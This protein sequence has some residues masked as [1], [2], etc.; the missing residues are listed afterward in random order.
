M[1]RQ[2][3][4]RFWIWVSFGL[5][6][7]M[8][9]VNA[10]ANIIPING[11]TTGALSDSYFNLFAP[12]GL[13]FTVWGVIYL[14]LGVYVLR[15]IQ[16]LRIKEGERPSPIWIRV[17]G[18]LALSSLFNALWIL[19]WHYRAILVSVLLML[20]ILGCL[21]LLSFGLAKTDPLTKVTFGIYFGWITVAT[22]ANI[23]TYLVSLGVPDNTVGATIQ[24][25]I[26]LLVGIAIGVATLLIQKNLGYGVVFVW[27]YLGIYLKHVDPLQFDRGYPAV[28]N[29]ALFGMILLLLVTGFIVGK[30]IVSRWIAAKKT[31]ESL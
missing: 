6:L 26:I 9:I 18:L 1:F 25:M 31:K 11:I 28:Y 10:L 13:T 2:E 17:N 22:I 7:V 8:I 12:T 4:R 29:T 24:T 27:A 23:T 16:S 3:N 5:Y 14:L 19:A 20:L 30:P 15:Q 21:I